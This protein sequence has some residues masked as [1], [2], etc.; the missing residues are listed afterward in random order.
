MIELN[1][2]EKKLILYTKGHYRNKNLMEALRIITAW[3]FQIPLES[4]ESYHIYD[5]VLKV[6][7]QLQEKGYVESPY[8]LMKSFFTLRRPTI[9]FDS[10]IDMMI[11]DLSLSKAEG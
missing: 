10:I 9:T 4:T 11:S 6:F 3:N 2:G 8:D 5:F 7:I 1:Y